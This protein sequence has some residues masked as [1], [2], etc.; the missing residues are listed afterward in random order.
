MNLYITI[1]LFILIGKF[2]LNLV[3]EISNVEHASLL[4]PEEFVGVYDAQ[5]YSQ[6]QSY[7][8]EITYFK[9]FKEI[10]FT[11]LTVFFI[12]GG[13][14]N[15][16]DQIARSFNCGPIL[17]GLI[18]AG[19]LLLIF[20]VINI[21]FSA[22]YTFVIED[23]YGFNRSTISTFI[24]DILKGL[25]LSIVIG[26]MVL[27]GILWFFTRGGKWGWVYCWVAVVLFQIL[28]IFIAPVVL[29]PIFNKF[30]PLEEGEVKHAIENYLKKQNFKM[31][32][33]FKMDASRRSTK[34]NA[35]FTGLGRFKRIVLFDTL[36]KR[37]TP[38]E[39][40]SILAH[41]VGHYKKRH[42][43][44]SMILFTATV[45]IMFFLLSVFINNFHFAA[46]KMEEPSVYV[47]LF[48]FSFFYQ[49]LHLFFTILSN[50]FSRKYEYE[51]DAFAVLTYKNP[52]AFISALKKI[53][54]DNLSNLTPSPLKVFF[55]YSHPPILKRIEAIRKIP[56]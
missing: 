22:Y 7:L 25:L 21:P 11:L 17:T 12:I 54:R 34:S 47:S 44:K 49:P 8:K 6:S 29:L 16:T 35:F 14:V 36:I 43:I 39:I 31:K 3:I 41:E 26:G 15:F 18:F 1:I 45:G 32:G 28:L 38:E 52:S 20:Q 46:F 48:F 51:A 10:I 30:T 2:I 50:Y 23:K 5:R 37:H 40:V 24:L 42:V 56:V 19:I 33:I 4:L 55:S 53:T 9:L 27:A 13:G